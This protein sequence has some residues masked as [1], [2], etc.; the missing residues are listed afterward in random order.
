K[1]YT[2]ISS[3][4]PAKAIEK[5]NPYEVAETSAVGRAL[6][7]ANYCLIEGVASADEMIQSTNENH[8]KDSEIEE[9]IPTTTDEEN[10]KWCSQHS[11]PMVI[12]YSKT[13]V[14]ANN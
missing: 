12:G 4:N 7:F 11:E 9:E 6:G 13:K 3:A 2:G 8:S 5:S 14:D 1:T 10:I